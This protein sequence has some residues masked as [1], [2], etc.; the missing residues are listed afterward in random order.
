VDKKDIETLINAMK[1]F[2]LNNRNRE[3]ISEN[4]KKKLDLYK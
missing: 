4:I 2:D 3:I 1:E